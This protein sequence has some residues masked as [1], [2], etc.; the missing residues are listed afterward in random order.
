MENITVGRIVITIQKSPRPLVPVTPHHGGR[1]F[2]TCLGCIRWFC[3]W[4]RADVLAG[5]RRLLG[6]HRCEHLGVLTQ[7][8]RLLYHHILDPFELR[9][10]GERKAVRHVIP[11]RPQDF[12]PQLISQVIGRGRT[13]VLCQLVHDLVHH[14]L[15]R[16]FEIAVLLAARSVHP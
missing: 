16:R 12:F 3:L 2:I 1:R 7:P 4:L 11:I 8:H 6:I 15:Q 10:P 5:L 9:L 13:G 14:S